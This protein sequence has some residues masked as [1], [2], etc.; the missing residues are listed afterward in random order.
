MILL[1]SLHQREIIYGCYPGRKRSLPNK[2]HFVWTGFGN[3][4]FRLTAWYGFPRRTLFK[5]VLIWIIVEKHLLT[6]SE[7]S[8]ILWGNFQSLQKCLKILA[9]IW[10]WSVFGGYSLSSHAQTT[11]SISSAI[12]FQSNFAGLLKLPLEAI[13]QVF[14]NVWKFLQRSENGAFSVGY[15]LSSH[16]QTT[17]SIS[18]AIS[19]QPNFAG[20]L[21]LPL[22]YFFSKKIIFSIC[23]FSISGLNY[24]I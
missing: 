24:L 18:S 14:K 11:I 7:I 4:I 8:L 13:S 20:L 23:F 21:K 6:F 5:N 19:F 16:A 17:I 15:S 10:K 3:M 2:N 9:E 12:S 1:L 22:L